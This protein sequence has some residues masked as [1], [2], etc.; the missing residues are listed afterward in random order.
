MEQYNITNRNK[1]KRVAK[2]ASYDKEAVYKVLDDSFLCHISF[3]VA[4]QPFIIPTIYG[5][6]RNTLFIHGATTSRMIKTLHEGVEMSLAVTHLDGIVLARSAFHHSANYRSV[7]VFG[8]AVPVADEDKEEALFI[9]SEQV[10]PGR[11][12]EVRK[13]NA[14]ELKATSVLAVDI[15]QASVKIRQGGPVDDKEDYE[16]DVWAGLVPLTLKKSEP[17]GDDFSHNMKV[18]GSIRNYLQNG[19]V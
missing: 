4:D 2:R 14:K 13:P 15:E 8:R 7:V 11:W 1:V 10:M 18:S 5:R 12:E 9:I 6:K 17:I 3:V 19:F 16:L